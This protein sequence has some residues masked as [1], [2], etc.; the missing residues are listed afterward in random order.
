MTPVSVVMAVYNGQRFLAE[1]VESVL[2]QTVRELELIVVDD[3][4][5]DSSPSILRALAA[6]DA[7]L[8]VLTV[9]HGGV[10]G[11]ANT[12]I[13]AARYGLIARTDAD[14][15]MLPHRLERQ[16]AFWNARPGLAATCGYCY[17]IDAAGKRIGVSARPFDLERGKRE[18]QP[19]LFVEFPNS[20]TLFRKAAFQAVGGYRNLAYAEDRDLWGRLVTAGYA[21]ACQPEYLAEFR[22]HGGSLTMRHAAVQHQLCTYIDNNVIR[23]LQG[24]PEWSLEEFREWTRQRPLP[25][26]LRERLDFGALHA[27][28]RASRHYGERRWCRCALALAA[29]VALNPAHILSRTLSKIRGPEKGGSTAAIPS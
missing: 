24:A 4:S 11:A 3:G 8:R 15:R 20:T 22:L 17:F 12:G 7:R 28:K 9:A 21:I 18:L 14:D 5:T 6:R 26:R 27:F 13:A 23:R 10:P 25:A 1:A 29:A 2:A 16:L 19:P